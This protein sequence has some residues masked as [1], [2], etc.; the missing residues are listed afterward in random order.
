MS[1]NPF[2]PE[3]AQAL[4]PWARDAAEQRYPALGVSA[5]SPVQGQYTG[6]PSNPQSQQQQLQPQMTTGYNSASPAPSPYLQQQ[7]PVQTGYYGQQP[8]QQPMQ[9]GYAQ[10][11]SGYNTPSQGRPAGGGFHPSTSFGQQLQSEVNM[12][13]GVKDLDPYSNIPNTWSQASSSSTAPPPQSQQPAGGAGSKEWGAHPRTILE[14]SKAALEAWDPSAWAA[15]NR[16]IDALIAAWTDRRAAVLSALENQR[17][18]ALQFDEQQRVDQL[19]K[20]AD[21]KVDSLT[22]GKFQIQEV[23]SGYRVRWPFCLA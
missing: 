9:T 8:Q 4:N 10:Q 3:P 23:E 20:D 7:Q 6:Y 17:G 13:A 15:L 14:H 5:P 2:A 19:L 11:Q 1:T 22:A 12:Y 21:E 18:R 16:R